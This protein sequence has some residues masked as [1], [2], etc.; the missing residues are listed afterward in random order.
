M[1][2]EGHI[3]FFFKPESIALIGASPNPE[4][5]SCTIL[6][7]LLKMGFQGKVYSVNPGY[8]EIR[9]LKC[10]PTP[11]EIK[12]KIDIAIFAVPASTVLEILKGPVENIKGA[13][14]VSSGFR[15]IGPEG[16]EMEIRLKEILEEKRI[17][18]MGPNCLRIYDTASKV[19]TFFISSDKVERPERLGF[20]PYS[21]RFL[22]RYLKEKIQV[23]MFITSI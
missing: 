23:F 20:S 5:L 3:D 4:K 7:S 14:I 21:E 11:S 16:K 9:G 17:R 2:T 15:E 18:A 1:T 13:I 22:C 19:D 10:Y 6:E 8:Q 12:D